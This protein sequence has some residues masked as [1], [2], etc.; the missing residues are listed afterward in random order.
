MLKVPSNGAD[1]FSSSSSSATQQQQQHRQKLFAAATS[2]SC[3]SSPPC[4]SRVGVGLQAGADSNLP[5]PTT[6]SQLS[7]QPYLSD[8][9]LHNQQQQQG[10]GGMRKFSGSGSVFLPILSMLAASASSVASQQQQQLQQEALRKEDR[11]NSGGD[12]ADG[13]GMQCDDLPSPD[14]LNLN[15]SYTNAHSVVS[16]NKA[17]KASPC[18][19]HTIILSAS[20]LT[21]HDVPASLSESHIPSIAIVPI[22]DTLQKHHYL[23]PELVAMENGVDPTRLS[24][25]TI[26][27]ESHDGADRSRRLDTPLLDLQE[28]GYAA[29]AAIAGSSSPSPS[30]EVENR[31]AEVS[32]V[33]NRLG[34]GDERAGGVVVEGEWPVLMM[35][36]AGPTS[37]GD[38][39]G[40]DRRYW[41]PTESIEDFTSDVADREEI[42]GAKQPTV[43][44][45]ISVTDSPHRR[46]RFMEEI[47]VIPSS[48]TGSDD[49][50]NLTLIDDSSDDSSDESGDDDNNGDNSVKEFLDVLPATNP[51]VKSTLSEWKTIQVVESFLTLEGVHVGTEKEYRDGG[52]TSTPAIVTAF[53]PTPDPWTVALPPSP[54]PS[55]GT[56]DDDEGGCDYDHTMVPCPSTVLL[57]LTPVTTSPPITT[58]TSPPPPAA[59]TLKSVPPTI[60]TTTSTA[61]TKTTDENNN[62]NTCI[63]PR[64][65]ELISVRSQLH[66]WTATATYL[67]DQEQ[68]L[69]L[70]IDQLV[71]VMA[72]VIEKCQETEDELLDQKRI[73]FELRL[74]LDKEREIGFASI[75]EAALSNREKQ[76][77]E[78]ELEKSRQEVENLRRTCVQQQCEPEVERRVLSSQLVQA[79]AQNRVQGT[80]Q[81]QI[82]LLQKQKEDT[83][84]N[85]IDAVDEEEVVEEQE[86]DCQEGQD[87]DHHEM[88]QQSLLPI[89]NN[90][91]CN[92]A[93]PAHKPTT[94]ITFSQS[95]VQ[96]KDLCSFQSLIKS[97]FLFLAA[98][99]VL[100]SITI[101]ISGYQH[102]LHQS[103]IR[104][105][106]TLTFSFSSGNTTIL[107]EYLQR[108]SSIMAE[109]LKNVNEWMGET[110]P[111]SV[112]GA[113]VLFEDLLFMGGGLGLSLVWGDQQDLRLV[114]TWS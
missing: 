27:T 71:Q 33:T 3:F 35:P 11:S 5:H 70:H 53:A 84:E 23:T 112:S 6:H 43:E 45:E 113:R 10:G 19:P 75:Q 18:A 46:V 109:K 2:K 26:S 58:T 1:L 40:L 81:E 86:V 39:D 12:G 22:T 28:Q 34:P 85:W 103:F 48:R 78:L 101:L 97:L 102:H 21:T 7:P 104:F 25:S 73:V 64:T 74:E 95:R 114:R 66:Y 44:S 59:T 89:D 80:V 100:V 88:E 50:D 13:N 87:Q 57:R 41:Q 91:N 47:Q 69:T 49:D 108:Y 20:S 111:N 4:S 17:D 68:D 36:R 76:L 93:A 29:A 62:N 106:N 67:R 38:G 61:H 79:Q 90:H 83:Q 30:G 55:V 51:T 14:Y 77:L 60:K 54:N 94:P 37:A 63:S 72:D 24:L 99:F 107:R 52:D 32:I 96:Q 98:T 15:N 31:H 8:R 16:I 65:L 9:Q 105:L 82:L 56:V 42:Q 92:N 110:V